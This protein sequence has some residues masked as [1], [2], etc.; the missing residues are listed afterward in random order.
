MVVLFET[1]KV[2][3]F[4]GV[5]KEGCN[6]YAETVTDVVHSGDTAVKL[7]LTDQLGTSRSNVSVK[8]SLQEYLD[9]LQYPEL[10][11]SYW[12]MIPSQPHFK[13]SG[14]MNLDRA[15][16]EQWRDANFDLNNFRT[17]GNVQFRNDGNARFL[18][19]GASQE[20]V[21]TYEKTT[22]MPLTEVF[23]NWDAWSF[24]KWFRIQWHIKRH[25]D[26]SKSYLAVY[27]GD[28]LV[29]AV[30]AK[31]AYND[32]AKSHH[33]MISRFN[34]YITNVPSDFLTVQP[35]IMHIDDIVVSD[36]YVPLDY[37]VGEQEEEDKEDKR[38]LLLFLAILAVLLML[39][40]LSGRKEE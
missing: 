33:G 32:D 31:T 6:G 3:D 34:I 20:Y 35:I 26:P 39:G 16:W 13:R 17:G 12:C 11:I 15:I 30:N 37:T 18:S 22:V 25:T 9:F 14:S 36:E 40:S 24:D 29:K 21:P 1:K 7:V 28:K 23:N 8:K 19:F 10:F 38:F 5:G 4:D 27:Y 2:E